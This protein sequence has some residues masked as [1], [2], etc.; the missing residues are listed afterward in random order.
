MEEISIDE[1]NKLIKLVAKEYDNW[2]DQSD[3]WTSLEMDI[4]TQPNGFDIN[5]VD[6]IFADIKDDEVNIVLYALKDRVEG[7]EEEK[8][9]Y[10]KEIDMSNNFYCLTVKK[11][12][13][14]A[15]HKELKQ[16]EIPSTIQ[17]NEIEEKF[18]S[19]ISISV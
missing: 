12:E 4:R 5:I 6:N 15:L 13:M 14:E 3:W 11:S 17:E 8:I 18:S 9:K 7:T 2:I 10:P 16:K 1:K 19:A